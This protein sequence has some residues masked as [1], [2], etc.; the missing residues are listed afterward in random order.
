M[1]FEDPD[2][3]AVE[4]QAVLI[5]NLFQE[6]PE[7]TV[8]AFSEGVRFL[9]LGKQSEEDGGDPGPRVYSFSKDAPLIFAAFHQTH[10]VDLSTADLHWWIFQALF[11]DLGADTAF[12]N[13]ISLRRRVKTGKAT[14]DERQMAREMGEVFDI[15]ETDAR[16]L[17]ERE[18]EAEFMRLINQGRK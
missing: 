6:Q 12:C 5:N 8:L 18:R 1:A 16:T 10:G 11:M 15:P 9:N 4:K 3:A 13:L 7:N 2:L 14:K 17:E